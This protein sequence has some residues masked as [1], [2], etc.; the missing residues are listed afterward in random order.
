PGPDREFSTSKFLEVAESLPYFARDSFDHV[1]RLIEIF[2]KK[3][4]FGPSCFNNS[5]LLVISVNL[6]LVRQLRIVMGTRLI[7]LVCTEN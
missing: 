7:P 4:T 5:T 3:N 6:P 1:Y 2:L